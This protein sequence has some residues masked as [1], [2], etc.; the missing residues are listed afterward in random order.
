MARP[1]VL[2]LVAAVLILA[3][4]LWA[5]LLEPPDVALGDLSGHLDEAVDVEGEVTTWRWADGAEGREARIGLVDTVGDTVEVRWTTSESPPEEGSRIRVRG[6][7]A[8][9]QGR[10]W[11]AAVGPGA[12]TVLEVGTP[13]AVS[14]QVLGAEPGSLADGPVEVVG[15]MMDPLTPEGGSFRLSDLPA[16]QLHAVSV[17]HPGMGSWLEAGSQ[18]RVT[19]VLSWDAAALRWRLLA[20]DG[21]LEVLAAAGPRSLAWEEVASGWR[22]MADE[23]VTVD[24]VVTED[25]HGRW[26]EAAGEEAAVRV[27]LLGGPPVGS[28]E[29]GV[30]GRVAWDE[31]G[32]RLCLDARGEA[33]AGA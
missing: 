32:T 2:V 19:G 4:D 27:C 3:L 11:I 14:W 13:T 17:E 23:A 18:V 7:V 5:V 22:Y 1:W 31:S 12:V 26:L 15:W 10:I 6:E 16:A 24:G 9:W 30:T 33:E 8:H 25:A 20:G 29:V 28:G 21:G